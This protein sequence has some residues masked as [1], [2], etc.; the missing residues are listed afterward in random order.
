MI[1]VNDV[2]MFNLNNA[3]KEARVALEH[4][5]AAR[6]MELQLFRSYRPGQ[7]VHLADLAAGREFHQ[8]VPIELV[9]AHRHFQNVIKI[10]AQAK[11]HALRI[12]ADDFDPE[13]LRKADE[14]RAL[15]KAKWDALSP[16]EKAARRKEHDDARDQL[17]DFHCRRRSGY[18]RDR[19]LITLPSM[20]RSG[21]RTRCAKSCVRPVF[22]SLR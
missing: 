5:E 18:F 17:L 3:I 15:A 2:S 14:E 16:E 19:P 9:A 21:S 8:N 20:E 4:L 6:Q 1:D 22:G 13:D 10:V 11:A 12:L 7:G